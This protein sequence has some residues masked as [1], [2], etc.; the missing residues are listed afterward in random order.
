[1][2]VH[3]RDECDTGF[4]QVNLA[5][6]VDITDDE[7]LAVELSCLPVHSAGVVNLKDPDFAPRLIIT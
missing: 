2:L 6:A 4:F 7:V 1:M 5:G 3:T